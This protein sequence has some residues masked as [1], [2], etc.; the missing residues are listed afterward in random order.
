MKT[1]YLII[2]K[3]LR[4]FGVLGE[5]R[6]LPITDR[7]ERFLDLDFIYIKK[8]N[9]GFSKLKVEAARLISAYAQLKL[10]GYNSRDDVEPLRGMFLYIDREHAVEIDEGSYYYYDIIG[11]SVF[12]QEGENLGRVFD[13]QNSGSND[14]YFVRSADSGSDEILIPAVGDVIKEID[15]DRKKIVINMIEGLV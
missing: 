15:I 3:F 6:V 4:P 8:R 14:V 13:V 12:T 11:C 10:H 7:A 5:I 9:T 2:G 1:D